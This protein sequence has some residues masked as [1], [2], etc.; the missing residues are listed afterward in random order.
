MFAK[1]KISLSK[2]LIFL[3][4]F[5]GFTTYFLLGKDII[6]FFVWWFSLWLIGFIFWPLSRKIFESFFDEGWLFSKTIGLVFLTL[7][8]WFLSSLKILPFTYFTILG[9]LVLSAI[10][11]FKK[12][13]SFGRFKEIFIWEEVIFFCA[14]VFFSFVRGQLPDIHGIEKFMDFA[15][16]NN[17]LRTKFMPPVDMWL[18]GKPANYYY[19]GHY[20]FAFLTK[21]TGIPS[22]I[23]YN[24]GVATLFAFGFSLT[25]SL[26]ANLF[27][28]WGGEKTI[29]KAISAGLISAFLLSLG[30]NLHTFVYAVLLPFAKNIGVYQGEVKPYFYADPRSYIGHYPPTD[31]KLITEFPAYSYVLG[32]LHAQIIGVCFTITFIALL[33]A[34]FVKEDRKTFMPFEN[35]IMAL[36]LPVMWMTNTWDFPIYF[37]VMGIVF[38][39]R[40]FLKYNLKREALQT[41]LMEILKILTI[42]LVLLLPFLIN[43]KNP[44]QGIHLTRLSHLLSPL[45]WFQLFV[46]WGYQSFFAILFIIYIFFFEP[47]N[48]LLKEPSTNFLSR[49]HKFFSKL[50]RADI[51]VL[52][53]IFCAFGLVWFS[54]FFYQKDIS[55]ADFY[56]ANTVW[57]VTLQAFVLFDIVIGYI[58]LRIIPKKL[59]FK[60]AILCLVI[61]GII[62]LPMLYP[63]WSL[64]QP[65]DR[66]RAYKGLD[67]TTFLKSLYPDDYRGIQWLNNSIFGQP[68]IVE[69][70]GESYTDYARVSVFTGLPTIL[71]WRVHEWYWRGFFDEPA[72]RTEEVRE[73]YESND[74]EKTKLLLKK[75]KVSYIFVGSLERQQYPKLNE[76][77][78]PSLGEVVFT[79]GETKIYKIRN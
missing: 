21:L 4:L 17:L 66:L 37:G 23:A 71:G 3:I 76:Q 62:C 68:T 29:K 64:S 8:L 6:S 34:F 77:K 70:V 15:F 43:F 46:V 2:K 20:V 36:I 52:I 56:R 59:N 67:G 32:D 22:A 60:K 13:K 39:V 19:Y 24:L 47:R 11:I 48:L 58:V 50:S 78:L 31:D 27:Y 5:L 75:Y 14:L 54:E 49:L 53:I 79:S 74:L 35:L 65:Y 41:T 38:L 7:T 45:Y 1:E 55:G 18:A 44:T 10:V 33:L 57:K 42:S 69:A 40:S 72:K 28:F 25:F 26:T 12:F 16:L 30:G 61:G 63:I 73:I 51:F 9:L